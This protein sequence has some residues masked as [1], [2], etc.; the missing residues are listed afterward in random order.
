MTLGTDFDKIA[1]AV[2]L[3]QRT[4]DLQQNFLVVPNSEQDQQNDKS[5][6]VEESN[7]VEAENNSF[8]I[9]NPLANVSAPNTPLAERKSLPIAPSSNSSYNLMVKVVPYS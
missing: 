5:P 7:N 3:S 9:S 2:V 6:V 4:R 8:I 1:L